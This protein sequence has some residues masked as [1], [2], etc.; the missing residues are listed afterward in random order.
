MPQYEVITPDGEVRRVRARSPEDAVCR[1]GLA[2]D[3]SEVEMDAEPDV[4]GW[5]LVSLAGAAPGPASG[6]GSAEVVGRV[7]EFARMRFRRD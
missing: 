4:H 2:D 5:R 3:V 7:R 6:A 1:A